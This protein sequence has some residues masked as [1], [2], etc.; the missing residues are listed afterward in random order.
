MNKILRNKRTGDAIFSGLF[1]LPI[2]LLVGLFIV[3]PI[4]QSVIMSFQD[5]GARNLISGKPGTWN[6]FE[7]YK[8]LFRS[9]LIANSIGITLRFVAI[10]VF[11]EFFI[12]IILALILNSKI[13]G[14]RFLR[15]LMMMPWVVPTIVSAL[16]WM[17][18]FQ[19]QYGV[20]K[21]LVEFLSG[22]AVDNFAMLNNPQTALWGII[23][24][25]LWK[26]T[27]LMTLLLLAG[28]SN[29]SE[30]LLE[31]ATIDGANKFK[32]FWKIILPSLKPVIKVSVLMAIIENFK[33]FP[34]FWTMTGG[35]PDGATET[36]AVLS[37]REAFVSFNHG[38]GAAV[39]TIWLLIMIVIVI[40]F[41]M[42]FRED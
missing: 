1:L 3:M 21:A 18:I 14:A 38:S 10:V 42:A 7:N 24:A 12:G 15:S 20:F 25:A 9:G 40:L 13:K 16:I 36:L 27:P 5:Y 39:T 23:L 35:G 8:S 37:Y 22:G 28:L 11:F 26:L 32:L 17:W 30:D 4:I 33:Q 41:N 2:I 29:I 6:N 31:A 19:P 34:L